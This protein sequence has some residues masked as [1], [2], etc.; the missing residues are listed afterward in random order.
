MEDVTKLPKWAQ[1]KIAQLEMRLKESID[2]ENIQAQKKKTRV[3]IPHFRMEGNEAVEFFLDD[4]DT[5]RFRFG[6]EHWNYIDVHLEKKQIQLMGGHG[7][8]IM[9]WA[10]NVAKVGMVPE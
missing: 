7:I 1:D 8:S 6:P 4:R 10:T 2:R 9:P 3:S 5:F